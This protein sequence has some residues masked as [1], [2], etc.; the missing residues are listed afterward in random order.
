[1]EKNRDFAVAEHAALLQG[2]GCAFAAALFAEEAGSGGGGANA[3]AADG[4]G[5]SETTSAASRSAFKLNSVGAQFRRQLGGLMLALSECSPH[6]IRCVK[7]NPSSLPGALEPEYVLDQLRAGGVLEAVRIACAG[8]PT[9]KPFRPFV[10]RYG[11][12]L[13]DP[14]SSSS[15]PSIINSSVRFDVDSLDDASAA[16]AARAIL[17]AALPAS[18]AEKGRGSLDRGWQIGKTRVFLRAGQLAALEGARGRRL[19]TSALAI[20]AAWRGLAA[21]RHLR[22]AKRAAATIQAHWRGRQARRRARALRGAAAAVVIQSRWRARAARRE[23]VRARQARRAVTIQRFARGW[24]ARTRF[25]RATDLGR[26]QAARA[27]EA[28]RRDAAATVIQSAARGRAARKLVAAKRAEAEQVGR[29]G[30][31]QRLPGDAEGA[32]GRR[33]RRRR[34]PGGGRR[35][36]AGEAGFGARRRPGR[37]RRGGGSDGGKQRRKDFG[38]PPPPPPSPSSRLLRPPPPPPCGKRSS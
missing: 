21:R 12:L 13:A 11:V 15:S 10:R 9:R 37:A 35:S 5:G 30:G 33:R 29:D 6:Y 14:C 17:Q 32:A 4:G 34:G 22:D 18:S 38:L 2:S 8:F 20:Q 19:T 26:R 23:F 27:A 3:N 36:G 25:R 28:S 31:D 1:M 16:A 24:L 7:P